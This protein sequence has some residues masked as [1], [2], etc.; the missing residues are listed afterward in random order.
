MQEDVS[1]RRLAGE[2][3]GLENHPGDPE[4]NDVVARYQRGGWEVALEVFGIG[5]WPAHRRKW[6]QGAGEPGI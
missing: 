6:P 4:E 3:Q 2:L 5:V 1:K